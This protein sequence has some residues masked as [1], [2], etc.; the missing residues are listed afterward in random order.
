M[1]C[2]KTDT[3]GPRSAR[4]AS[5][6]A[7]GA[8]VAPLE[9]STEHVRVGEEARREVAPTRLVWF[10]RA[11]R[12]Q[13]FHILRPV[14]FLSDLV[15]TSG[16]SSSHLCGRRTARGVLSSENCR[17]VASFEHPLDDMRSGLRQH[18]QAQSR[19]GVQ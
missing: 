2:C 9:A 8:K 17:L 3:F 10:R 6:C 12:K 11:A 18:S 15:R 13:R 16:P 4:L 7:G 1:A 19:L 5:A 14:L